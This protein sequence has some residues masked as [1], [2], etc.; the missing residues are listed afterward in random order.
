M[1]MHA[2]T[3]LAFVS[4][5]DVVIGVVLAIGET[6]ILLMLSLHPY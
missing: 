6:V 3:A 2:V 4:S 1:C 5:I